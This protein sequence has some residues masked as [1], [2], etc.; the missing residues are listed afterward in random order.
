MPTLLFTAGLAAAAA[1]A[2][3]VIVACTFSPGYRRSRAERMSAS[4]GLALTESVRPEVERAIAIRI[5]AAGIG[6]VLGIGLGVAIAA[7]N[8]ASGLGPWTFV[9]GMFLGLAAGNAVGALI[10][11]PRPAASGVRIARSRDVGLRDYVMPIELDG[12]RVTVGI[13][14]ATAII[15]AILLAGNPR[16]TTSLV[17]VLVTTA[18]AIAALVVLEVAG[19]ALVARPSPAE[20]PTRLAW[21]DALRADTL[22]NLVTPTL[23][24]AM[25]AVVMSVVGVF[26]ALPPSPVSVVLGAVVPLV[27]LAAAIVIGVVAIVSAPQRHYLRRLWPETAAAGSATRGAAR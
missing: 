20:D 24:F 22:R 15:V 4:V 2:M 10:A 26:G 18:L 5:R 11:R 3:I 21:E 6:A 12:S 23:T 1:L 27:L 19:R 17:T 9:A 7:V 13:A 14:A 16:E 25:I 8:P